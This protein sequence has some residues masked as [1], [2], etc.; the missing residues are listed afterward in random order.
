MF[1]IRSGSILLILI[2]FCGLLFSSLPIVAIADT[3][4]DTFE[5]DNLFGWTQA[6]TKRKDKGWQSVWKSENGVLD[7]TFTPPFDRAAAE[8]L[9]LTGFPIPAS[10]FTVRA[11]P[12][13][14]S[15]GIALGI[16][17]KNQ[18]IHIPGGENAKNLG[19]YYIFRASV[20][21]HVRLF[22]DGF[23]GNLGA[24]KLIPRIPLGHPIEIIFSEGKF[25]FFSAG[26]LYAQFFDEAYAKVDAVGIVCRGIGNKV[27]HHQ[28]DD[29]L[30]STDDM[31]L[32]VSGKHK[33]A[34]TWG[35]IKKGR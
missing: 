30:I 27:G 32:S 16:S 8:L 13:K 25:Q 22:T 34:M 6:M 24:D 20:I 17:G 4:K 11:T 14:G 19:K 33:L 26:R 5:D 10:K 18:P 12:V 15:L 1:Y 21:H 7:V 31:P 2:M 3:W 23:H 35:A 29:F 9:L 28:L